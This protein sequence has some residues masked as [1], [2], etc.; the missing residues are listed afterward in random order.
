MNNP[1]RASV[2]TPSQWV[3]GKSTWINTT[4][5][6]PTVVSGFWF[7]RGLQFLPPTLAIGAGG[8][9]FWAMA[10]EAVTAYRRQLALPLAISISLRR[11]NE[12]YAEFGSQRWLLTAGYSIGVFAWRGDPLTFMIG[13]PLAV[14]SFVGWRE[15][16]IANRDGQPSFINTSGGNHL[17][18]RRYMK[19]TTAQLRFRWGQ[20]ELDMA[21]LLKNMLL[22][23]TVG[24]GKTLII[25]QFMLDVLS[26]LNHFPKWRAV[27]I[28]PKWEFLSTILAL[29][30][31]YKVQLIH[32]GDMRGAAW[33]VATDLDN[34]AAI[35]EVTEELIPR[36]GSEQP[37]WI[38][39]S[40][41]LFAGTAI[42][43]NQRAPGKWRFS[44]LIFAVQ[45]V[46][47]MQT[48]LAL[49]PQTQATFQ[50]YA[51]NQKTFADVMSTLDARLLSLLPIAA[52]WRYVQDQDPQACVS[53]RH[54]S[55]GN[56][57]LMIGSSASSITSHSRI[58]RAIAKRM[59]QILLDGATGQSVLPP[60]EANRTMVIIDEAARWGKLDILNLVTN[61]R[62]YG[63]SVVLATQSI[64]AMQTH[65]TDKGGFDAVAAEFHTSAYLTCNSPITAKWMSDRAANQKTK[66]N[67]WVA[68]LDPTYFQTMAQ[69]RKISNDCVPGVY[70]NSS[71]GMW[72]DDSGV[73]LPTPVPGIPQRAPLPDEITLRPWDR[74]DLDRL[75]LL[76]VEE[77]L[78]GTGVPIPPHRPMP[79]SKTKPNLQTKRFTP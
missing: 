49:Y 11:D 12:E 5:F 21:Q 60:E 77:E 78:L 50:K 70:L 2:Q 30:P 75:N 10:A 62:D 17:V 45:E 4:Y 23:G 66:N 6:L 42:A 40:R 59:N 64:E 57:I 79:A 1:T 28:D 22:I 63:I 54:W 20:V 33:D 35:R 24:S 43:L 65:Y 39:A 55:T 36:E 51:A 69:N 53:I 41:A 71:L 52:A 48:I 34:E 29:V 9:V 67:R 27:I 19:G 31:R 73:S 58:V 26:L 32:P 16:T 8:L 46:Q 14:G 68:T 74:R 3:I 15:W 76:D 47:R 61:G 44:D 25:K 37:Y 18:P 38:E 56:T 7:V 13:V 72:F